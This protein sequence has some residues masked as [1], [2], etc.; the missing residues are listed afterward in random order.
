[1]AVSI[2]QLADEAGVSIAT[3][4]RVLNGKPYVKR[5]VHERVLR[6]ARE[7]NYTPKAKSPTAR[8]PVIV[9]LQAGRDMG[10]YESLMVA[11][12]TRLLAEDCCHLELVRVEDHSVL[13]DQF[14]K[15][16]IALTYSKAAAKLLSACETPLI[17]INNPVKGALNVCARHYEQGYLAT[18]RLLKLGHRR[19]GLCISHVEGWGCNERARGYADAL[20]AFGLEPERSLRGDDAADQSFLAPVTMMLRSG[21]TAFA[22]LGHEIGLHVAHSLYLL[23]RRIPEDVSLVA[24]ENQGVSGCLNPPQTAVSQPVYEMAAFAVAEAVAVAKGAKFKA[25]DVD[26]GNELLERGS[27]CK[28]NERTGA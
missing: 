19:I 6:A 22:A 23:G 2:Q 15:V 7:L 27:T 12:L 17:S 14:A 25:S 21:A 18:E 10:I 28:A 3:V 24:T 5:D 26:F 1:M 20:R 9:E 16:A 11:R 4:S 8:I 13:K